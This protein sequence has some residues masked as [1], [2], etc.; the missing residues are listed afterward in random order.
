MRKVK[1]LECYK[2]HLKLLDI[3]RDGF[4]KAG[5]GLIPSWGT[6]ILYAVWP[7]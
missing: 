2:V 6:K 1:G 3:H 4:G 7:K 5:T